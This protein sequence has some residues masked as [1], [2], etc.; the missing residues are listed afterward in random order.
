MKRE[1]NPGHNH[2]KNTEKTHSS[3]DLLKAL[4]S[5]CVCALENSGKESSVCFS[6]II[7]SCSGLTKNLVKDLSL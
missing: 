5:C 7:I 2:R 3:G 1:S 4:V 6:E